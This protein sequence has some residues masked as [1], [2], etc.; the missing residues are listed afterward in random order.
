AIQSATDL[1]LAAI[2]SNG[3][4]IS[5]M[6]EIA[7]AISSAIEEQGAA[8]REIASNINQAADGTNQVSH[9][10]ATVQKATSGNGETATQML[11]TAVTLASQAENLRRR[12]DE[13]IVAVR[14]A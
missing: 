9:N 14:A 11:A 8:T 13:F 10:I 7:A 6:S 4:T 12:V 2:R 3:T 5:E 1:V